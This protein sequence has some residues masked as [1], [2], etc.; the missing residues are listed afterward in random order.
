MKVFGK[1]NTFWNTKM[2]LKLFFG[3]KHSLCPNSKDF[4]LDSIQQHGTS[5]QKYGALYEQGRQ[6]EKIASAKGQYFKLYRRLFYLFMRCFMAIVLFWRVY[7]I[8]I[9]SF[10]HFIRPSVVRNFLLL[11]QNIKPKENDSI[12]H[13]IN[14]HPQTLISDDL[15]L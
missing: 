1:L 7:F 10:V 3:I 11:T 15:S 6:G 2:S 8:S 14:I 13:K 4:L 9:L 5:Y 12:V